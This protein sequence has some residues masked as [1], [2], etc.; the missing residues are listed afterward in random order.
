MKQGQARRE[1]QS[2]LANSGK[3]PVMVDRESGGVWWLVVCVVSAG[4]CLR[5]LVGLGGHSGRGK[6]PIF[7]D[8]E[9]QRHW[10]E[11]SLSE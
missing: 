8:F 1:P 5:A 10:M 6:P 3:C 7:G 9:A 2:P 4:V 11:V